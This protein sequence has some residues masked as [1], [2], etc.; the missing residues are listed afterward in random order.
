MWRETYHAFRSLAKRYLHPWVSSRTTVTIETEQI[1]MVSRWRSTRAWCAE[2]DREVDMVRLDEANGF[3]GNGLPSL[4][5]RPMTPGLGETRRW[6][7]SQAPDGT[8]LIC[9]ESLRRNAE[10]RD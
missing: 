2:C 1:W 9:L 6:H 3:G 5:A 4:G 7:V 8:P 10:R